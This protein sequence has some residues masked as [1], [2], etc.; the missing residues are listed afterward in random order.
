MHPG[1]LSLLGPA[2]DA[3]FTGDSLR[4]WEDKLYALDFGS[5]SNVSPKKTSLRHSQA[6]GESVERLLGWRAAITPGH[7]ALGKAYICSF[8]SGVGPAKP[9]LNNQDHRATNP[10]AQTPEP[11]GTRSD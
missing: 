7:V 9:N 6:E 5:K 8:P 10:C 11:G 4:A 3:I 2:D 1:D